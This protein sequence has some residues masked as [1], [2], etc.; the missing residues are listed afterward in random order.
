M[1][2]K[3]INWRQTMT[4]ALVVV[5]LLFSA[6]FFLLKATVEW[7]LDN[8]F[9][10]KVAGEI[11]NYH[12]SKEKSGI[13]KIEVQGK[14]IADLSSAYELW[15]KE[16][17]A[18]A[19]PGKVQIVVTDNRDQFLNKVFQKMNFYVQEGLTTGQFAKM[20]DNIQAIAEKEGVAGTLRLTLG[21]E[22]LYLQMAHDGHVL[23]EVF[24][25]SHI[26]PVRNGGG[27][28]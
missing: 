2:W 3:N 9:K 15:L 20:A 4:I 7:P 17:E 8:I 10:G 6:Q 28:S 12:I 16:A 27:A 1:D 21:Q 23:Y 19:G 24:D 25:R 5:T 13:Y 22:R 18:V 26:S 11:A 14:N